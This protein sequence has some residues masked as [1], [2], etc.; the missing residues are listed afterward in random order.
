MSIPARLGPG[1]EV[2]REKIPRK[3]RHRKRSESRKKQ[4]VCERETND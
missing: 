2:A 1:V 4:S 3:R